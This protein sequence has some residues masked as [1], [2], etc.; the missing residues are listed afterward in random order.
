MQVRTYIISSGQS[1]NNV[2]IFKKGNKLLAGI[3]ISTLYLTHSVQVGWQ[4]FMYFPGPNNLLYFTKSYFTTSIIV[5]Q[6]TG[7]RNFKRT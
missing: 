1:Y 3:G 2:A 7:A 6:F 4:F 5:F